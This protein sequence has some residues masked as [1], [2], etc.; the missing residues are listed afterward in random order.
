M[1]ALIL[2]TLLAVG[3][4]LAASDP[5]AEIQKKDAALQDYLA[6]NKGTLTKVQQ[7]SLKFLINGI[8]DFS[9]LGKRSLGS[10]WDSLNKPQQ[11][12]FIAVFKRMVENTSIKRL[13]NYRSDSARYTVSGTG[14]KTVVKGKVWSKGKSSSVDYKLLQV[15]GRWRAWDLVL[16]GM[17]TLKNYRDQFKEIIK[18]EK[19]E[20][21]LKRLR[22][23]AG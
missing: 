1:R 3:T 15:N 16:D 12:T 22:K 18:K 13:E 2:S 7:D 4:T 23:N 6:K 9:E 10:Q 5:V 20:G 11:D 21:L 19:F 8:F 14:E 17:S